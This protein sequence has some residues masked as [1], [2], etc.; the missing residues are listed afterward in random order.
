VLILLQSHEEQS[1]KDSCG[2]IMGAFNV[3]YHLQVFFDCQLLKQDVFLLAEADAAP[4]TVDT[5]D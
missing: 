1:L 4:D 3:A 5:G 2:C